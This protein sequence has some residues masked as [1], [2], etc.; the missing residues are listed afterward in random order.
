MF[1]KRTK[2]PFYLVLL[3]CT[4]IPFSTIFPY[5]HYY[6]ISSISKTTV[7][8]CLTLGCCDRGLQTGWVT[9]SRERYRVNQEKKSNFHFW[10]FK[11]CITYWEFEVL[12][13]TWK[14]RFRYYW[15]NYMKLPVYFSPPFFCILHILATWANIHFFI[16]GFS[17]WKCINS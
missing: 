6:F 15:H 10:F 9:Y 16:V 13:G 14:S 1:L 2:Q 4:H 12:P 17:K 5:S 8:L 11:L 7:G 3:N